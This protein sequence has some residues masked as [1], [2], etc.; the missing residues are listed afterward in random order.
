VEHLDAAI[1]QFDP[2]YKAESI[3]P[4]AFFPQ[5]DWAKRGEMTRIVLET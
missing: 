4:P 3:R 2:P 5:K 1:P